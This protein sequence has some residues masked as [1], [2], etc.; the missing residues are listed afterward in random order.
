MTNSPIIFFTGICYMANTKEE[1]LT[2]PALTNS[3]MMQIFF[4]GICYMANTK[5]K[6]LIRPALTN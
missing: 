1:G 5:E 2:R 3:G 4:T 6:G